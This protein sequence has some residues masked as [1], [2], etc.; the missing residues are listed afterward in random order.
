[1]PEAEELH[2]LQEQFRILLLSSGAALADPQ[3]GAH[4]A[5]YARNLFVA[6]T[7]TE[8]FSNEDALRIVCAYALGGGAKGSSGS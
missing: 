2:L 7:T 5:R 1:M 3:V 6:L 8:K 4:H